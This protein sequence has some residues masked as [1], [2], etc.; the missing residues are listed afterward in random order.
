MKKYKNALNV[1]NDD[2]SV[3]SAVTQKISNTTECGQLDTGSDYVLVSSANMH[4]IWHTTA[5]NRV[6]NFCLKFEVSYR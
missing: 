1:D 4:Q 5:F 3:A 6:S 2:V